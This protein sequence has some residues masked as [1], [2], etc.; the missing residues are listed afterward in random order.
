ML[1]TL[2]IRPPLFDQEPGARPGADPARTVRVLHPVSD[3]QAGQGSAGSRGIGKPGRRTAGATIAFVRGL[4]RRFLHAACVALVAVGSGSVLAQSE[5]PPFVVTPPGVVER[6]LTMAG[7]GP[8]DM[9]ID[10]GSGDGRIVIQ[11]AKRFGARGLGIEMNAGLVEASRTAA[12]R[13]GVAQRVRFEQADVLATDLAPASVLTLYLSAELNERLLPRILAAMRPGARVVSHDFAMANWTPDRIERMHA[14]EKNNG[15]GGESTLMLWIVP[16]DVA[17]QWQ[18]TIGE[19]GAQRSLE[20]RLAQ[21]FQ[22]LEAQWRWGREAPVALRASLVG[23][24]LVLEAPA[25]AGR[26][27]ARVEGDTLTGTWTD[28]GAT[29]V[30]RAHRVAT[31]PTLFEPRP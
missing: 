19:G 27:T 18:A 16:A 4:A 24:A 29:A 25:G 1:D 7:V 17:G 10:L 22:F 13:E 11:A 21:Q 23:A 20:V 12:R 5:L 3:V 6:M 28:A 31:R 2:D 26:I 9:L 14:P 15:R 8:D 30:F